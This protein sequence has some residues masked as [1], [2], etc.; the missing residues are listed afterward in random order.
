MS[1]THYYDVR[2]D[3]VAGQPKFALYYAGASPTEPAEDASRAATTSTPVSPLVGGDTYVFRQAH[4]TNNGYPL[5]FTTE[6]AHSSTVVSEAGAGTP[7][8]VGSRTRLVLTT[9]VLAHSDLY[10]NCATTPDM[11]TLRGVW[12]ARLPTA[13]RQAGFHP[14]YR[15]EDHAKLASLQGDACHLIE[16]APNGPWY[17]PGYAIHR[18]VFPALVDYSTAVQAP[19]ASQQTTYRPASRG[20]RVRR[21]VIQR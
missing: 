10:L 8:S 4:A 19:T 3:T 14:V 15:R 18:S 20:S 17:M 12:K 16:E 7:G 5:I 11:G 21:R 2:V 9:Q 1:E 6:A 13:E